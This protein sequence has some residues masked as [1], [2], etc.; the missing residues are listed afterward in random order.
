MAS[1]SS[2]IATSWNRYCAD[3]FKRHKKKL[4]S[5]YK[6]FIISIITVVADPVARTY[7][8]LSSRG[9][10]TLPLSPLQ[11]SCKKSNTD[12]FCVSDTVK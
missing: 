12:E 3:P 8:P 2:T 7:I 10:E 6:L 5:K 4:G 1:S 9:R 11:F